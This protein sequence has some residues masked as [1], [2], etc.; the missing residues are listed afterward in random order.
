MLISKELLIS[1]VG[2]L[3]ILFFMFFVLESYK[4]LEWFGLRNINRYLVHIE[5]VYIAHLFVLL[6]LGIIIY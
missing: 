3:S 6:V 4:I 2:V 5:D 1:V